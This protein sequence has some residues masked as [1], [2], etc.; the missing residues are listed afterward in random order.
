M[1]EKKCRGDFGKWIN[2]N[3]PEQEEQSK[4]EED[5]GTP[6]PNGIKHMNHSTLTQARKHLCL[7]VGHG[8]GFLLGPGGGPG[9]RLGL[10]GLGGLGG[11]GLGSAHQK[12]EKTRRADIFNHTTMQ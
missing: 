8:R 10:G 4:I 12:Q 7:G 5:Q 9:A 3:V 2:A 11:G 1:K 6:N